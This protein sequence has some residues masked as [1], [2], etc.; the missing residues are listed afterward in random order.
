[1]TPR[2][3]SLRP[4][5]NARRWQV[6]PANTGA[7]LLRLRHR[8]GSSSALRSCNGQP[9]PMPCRY[10]SSR[11]VLLA[12]SLDPIE[13]REQA[14]FLDSQGRAVIIQARR[15]AHHPHD[16]ELVA[17]TAQPNRPF[18]RPHRI[19]PALPDCPIYGETPRYEEPPDLEPIAMSPNGRAV[20]L[21][22]CDEGSGQ[23]GSQYLIRYT[24]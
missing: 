13:A 1:M 4:A 19:A 22:T 5:H 15:S 21:V 8:V 9:R 20:F 6:P 16:Y 17:L 12:P 10:S 2:G 7:I 24:P 3:R 14:G 23:K 11:H 18:E